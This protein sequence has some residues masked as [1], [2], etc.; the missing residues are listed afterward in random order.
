MILIQFFFSPSLLGLSVFCFTIAHSRVMEKAKKNIKKKRWVDKDIFAHFFRIILFSRKFCRIL[1]HFAFER[2]DIRVSVY[3]FHWN[4]FDSQWFPV[5]KKSKR[6]FR[7]EGRTKDVHFSRYMCI[8]PH[9]VNEWERFLHHDSAM[10]TVSVKLK[11]KM[12]PDIY[13]EGE[14]KN[15]TMKFKEHEVKWKSSFCRKKRV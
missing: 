13:L 1:Y 9:W 14:T 5:K 4:S 7:C 6:T 15:A 10:T 12:C 11:A 8:L 3:H 2:R